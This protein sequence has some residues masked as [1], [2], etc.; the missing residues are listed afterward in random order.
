MNWY[1]RGDGANL[2]NHLNLGI[3]FVATILVL[4]QDLNMQPP[5]TYQVVLSVFIITTIFWLLSNAN[6][7]V[8]FVLFVAEQQI[9]RH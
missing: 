4:F 9:N 7:F 8:C 6:S 1:H 5:N 3:N 2:L